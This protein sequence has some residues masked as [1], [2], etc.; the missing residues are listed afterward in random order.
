MQA[1]APL[2]LLHREKK[3]YE[4]AW[5]NGHSR[6]VKLRMNPNKTT[7]NNGGLLSVYSLYDDAIH[8]G[9]CIRRNSVVTLYVESYEDPEFLMAALILLAS[10]LL[11]S[12]VTVILRFL[13]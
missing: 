6:Y 11:T 9:S 12:N 10:T 4:G 2:Y 3:D 13:R 5:D 7:A 8:G 1:Q